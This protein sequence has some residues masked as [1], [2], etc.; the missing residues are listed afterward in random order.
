MRKQYIYSIILLSFLAFGC[1]STKNLFSNKEK[2][3]KQEVVITELFGTNW[4][5][6]KINASK[7]K[8][9]STENKISLLL[10]QEPM[11]FA[12]F[13]GCNRY[14]GKY[15]VKKNTIKFFEAGSTMM[16]CPDEDMTLER[17]YITAL[18]KINNYIIKSDTLFL[19]NNERVVLTYLE[20]KE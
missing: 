19:R 1:N 3:V 6:I 8:L 20:S 14:F 11:N 16:A 4:N 2:K 5:L 7:P 17:N 18:S 15:S 9:T 10:T 13:S 12:G